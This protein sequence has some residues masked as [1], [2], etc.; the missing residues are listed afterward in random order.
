M[1]DPNVYAKR[2]RARARLDRTKTP[3]VRRDNKFTGSQIVYSRELA[4]NVQH[5]RTTD[6]GLGKMQF[7]RAFD[8]VGELVNNIRKSSRAKFPERSEAFKGGMQGPGP[9]AKTAKNNK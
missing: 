3:K 8:H 9:R 6:D 5:N 4:G 7:V 2:V 1:P